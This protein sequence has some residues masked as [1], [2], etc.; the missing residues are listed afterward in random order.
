MP[1]RLYSRCLVPR[2]SFL[3]PLRLWFLS[4]ICAAVL[5]ACDDAPTVPRAYVHPAE[6][7]LWVAITV[8]Q[9]IPELSLWLPYLRGNASESARSLDR[10]RTLQA[11]SERARRA[12]NHERAVL[13]EEEAIQVMAGSLVT[14]PEVRLFLRSFTAFDAWLDRADAQLALTPLPQLE[15]VI[16]QVRTERRGAERALVEGDTVAAVALLATAALH[17]RE[18]SPRVVALRV[19]ERASARLETEGLDDVNSARA[20]RL[21]ANAR[22]ALLAGQDAR[23]LQ[24]ALYAL[25]LADGQVSAAPA[26]NRTERCR[27]AEHGCLDP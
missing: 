11:E 26:E 9:G 21:L 16:R 25:Q 7:E 17:V 14:M 3:P 19:L 10:V 12:G 1:A 5:A 2:F 24:R 22:E 8:P 15:H 27:D 13:L 18:Q 6:G 4:C 23:A 20:R